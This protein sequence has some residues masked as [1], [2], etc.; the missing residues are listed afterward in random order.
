VCK[1][2]SKVISNGRKTEALR[3]WYIKFR[4]ERRGGRRSRSKGKREKREREGRQ[5]IEPL[6]VATGGA[7]PDRD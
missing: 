2:E 7:F 6:E 4:V 1:K 5:S 3:Q